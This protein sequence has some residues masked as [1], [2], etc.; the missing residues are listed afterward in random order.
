[1]V[2]FYKTIIF[3]YGRNINRNHYYVFLLFSFGFQDAYILSNHNK[4]SLPLVCSCSIIACSMHRLIARYRNRQYRMI[5]PTVLSDRTAPIGF[6]LCSR[7][8]VHRRCCHGIH[9]YRVA[10]SVQ[11]PIFSKEVSVFYSTT[12][13]GRCI[14]EQN[15][16]YLFYSY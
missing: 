6:L 3:L 2:L 12:T 15:L 9:P 13:F 7:S 16:I 5:L 8:A 4:I 14:H 11:S 1:M 10:S